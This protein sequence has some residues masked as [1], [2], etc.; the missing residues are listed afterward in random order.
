MNKEFLLFV[1][2]EKDELP[3]FLFDIF[4]FIETENRNY[5]AIFVH[6]IKYMC[7]LLCCLSVLKYEIIFC[8]SYEIHAFQST[9][10][11]IQTY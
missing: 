3:N 4:C 10:V 11:V 1:K 6:C 9:M 2:W 7:K 5:K 8:Y